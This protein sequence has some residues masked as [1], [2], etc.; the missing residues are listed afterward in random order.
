MPAVPAWYLSGGSSNTAPIN[1]LGGAISTTPAP[2]NLFDDVTSTESSAGDIEYR[3]VYVKNDGNVNL[4]NTFVWIQVN[5]PDVDTSIAI[6][7]ASEGLNQVMQ[8]V[9]NENTSPVG[10]LFSAPASKGTGLPLG[11]I[12]AGQNYGIWV[13]RTVNTGAAAYNADTFTLRVEGDTGA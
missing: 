10:P 1:S 4:T 2:V 12:A 11:T 8:L 5:T 3:G 13:R 6:A 9:A 7:L